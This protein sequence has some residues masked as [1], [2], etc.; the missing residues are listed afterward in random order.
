MST[1]NIC[2]ANGEVVGTVDTDLIPYISNPTEGKPNSGGKH[3]LKLRVSMAGFAGPA[4][5]WQTGGSVKATA[6]AAGPAL[7]V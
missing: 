6:K 4:N 5:L 2:K 7:K 3:Y 1:F